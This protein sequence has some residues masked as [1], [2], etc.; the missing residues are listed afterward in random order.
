[1]AARAPLLLTMHN[2]EAPVPALQ[3][4]AE[5]AEAEATVE[6]APAPT[7]AAAPSPAVPEVML[8]VEDTFL[9]LAQRRPQH[10]AVA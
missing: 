4:Q 1:M 9:P 3:V 5:A 6:A 2:Q 8:E 7:P 10:G